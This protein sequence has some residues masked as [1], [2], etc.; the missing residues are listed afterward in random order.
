MS[1]NTREVRSE[2][3]RGGPGAAHLACL[4]PRVGLPCARASSVGSGASL[5]LSAVQEHTP[6][7]FGF[8]LS[9]PFFFSLSS[10]LPSSPSISFSPSFLPLLTLSDYQVLETIPHLSTLSH[11]IFIPY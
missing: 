11:F 5:W 10:F 6:P 3:D 1:T 2:R 4:R 9:F 8:P 7:C